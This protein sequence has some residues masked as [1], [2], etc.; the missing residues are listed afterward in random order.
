MENGVLHLFEP[1][2]ESLVEIH[3]YLFKL[4][5]RPE[6]VQLM[7]ILVQIIELHYRAFLQSSLTESKRCIRKTAGG[8]VSDELV[9]VC[10]DTT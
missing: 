10:A 3:T 2:Y 7:G 1:I 6:V 4:S 9:L 8:K 5:I